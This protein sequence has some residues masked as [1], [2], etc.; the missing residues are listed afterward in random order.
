[1]RSRSACV[2]GGG[3]RQ[4]FA[5]FEERGYTRSMNIRFAGMVGS[6]V[7]GALLLNGCASSQQ[8]TAIQGSTPEQTL[9]SLHDAASKSDEARYF[10]LFA[11]GG[12]VFLGTDAT[13]RWT[14]DEFKAFA[15]PYF[16][17][18]K[19]WTYTLQPGTRKI[20]IVRGTNV[21]YFD[22]LL[23]NA[24]LGTCRGSGVLVIENGQWRVGQYNLSIPVPNDKAESVV[25]LI[26]S[27][28]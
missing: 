19:G 1:M 11:K 18:G 27:G 6:G 28:K 2:R 8:S 14:L 24:K 5:R 23:N 12:S 16:S 20:N 4:R 9:T 25:K 3:E 7:L 22:E 26:H 10:D 17:Q 13:E 15:H 21:A